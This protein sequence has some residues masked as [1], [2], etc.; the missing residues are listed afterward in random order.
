MAEASRTEKGIGIIQK[1]FGKGATPTKMPEAFG[2]MTVEHLFGDV[3]SRPNLEITERSLITLS[4]LIVLGRENE[5]KIHIRGARNLGIPRAKI[6][7]VMIHL[8]HYG[9]W[10][11]AVSGFR[12][13][14][15]V[16]SVMDA[17]VTKSA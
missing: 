9:G 3:W 13:L 11:V 17:E 15:E 2:R 14:E 1:L 7:E 4:A 10:P 12:A 8:A 16:W 5:L 6:E